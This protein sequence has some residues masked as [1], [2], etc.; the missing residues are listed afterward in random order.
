M[1]SRGSH[2]RQTFGNGRTDMKPGDKPTITVI[3]CTEHQHTIP[4]ISLLKQIERSWTNE[5]D[6]KEHVMSGSDVEG[7]A[8]RTIGSVAKRSAHLRT[9][10]QADITLNCCVKKKC[11][12]VVVFNTSF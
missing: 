8:S 11:Y 9:I 5:C 10:I 6:T 2:E 4:H 1:E 12:H 3:P 7:R